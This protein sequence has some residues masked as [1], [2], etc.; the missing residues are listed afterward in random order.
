MIYIYNHD[1]QLK[2]MIALS[3]I[4]RQYYKVVTTIFIVATK[5]HIIATQFWAAYRS[6][7]Y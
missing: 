4:L 2:Y 7:K 6:N 1:A 5:L 3:L